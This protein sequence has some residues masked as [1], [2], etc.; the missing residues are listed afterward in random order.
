MVLCLGEKNSK[1]AVLCGELRVEH[2]WKAAVVQLCE[3]TLWTDNKSPYLQRL[4]K[5]PI[6]SKK[7]LFLSITVFCT[8]E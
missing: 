7:V 6:L 5:S 2:V 1:K 3:C 8:A 4:N